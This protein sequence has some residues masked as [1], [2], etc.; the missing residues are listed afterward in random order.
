MMVEWSRMGEAGLTRLG[1]QGWELVS[2]DTEAK[3]LGSAVYAGG[4][5]DFNT[6]TWYY[7]KRPG[8]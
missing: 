5:Q 2:V 7:F 8:K 6:E 4:P 1:A 3:S